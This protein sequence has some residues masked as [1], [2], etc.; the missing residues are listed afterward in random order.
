MREKSVHSVI[1][2]YQVKSPIHPSNH[3][4]KVAPIALALAS[5]QVALSRQLPLRL[6]LMVIFAQAMCLWCAL[7]QSDVMT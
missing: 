6:S 5:R 7:R 4:S 3:P 1:G 2:T